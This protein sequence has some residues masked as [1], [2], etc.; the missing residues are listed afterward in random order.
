MFRNIDKVKLELMM[1]RDPEYRRVVKQ[2]LENH[3]LCL[4]SVSHEIRNPL[5]LISS[6]MQLIQAQHPEVIEFS[7]WTQMMEDVEF[8]IDLANEIG[9]FSNSDHMHMTLFSMKHT[10]ECIILSFAM[11]LEGTNIKITGNIEPDITTYLGDRVKIQ[12]VLL[13]LLTNARQAIQ[14]QEPSV[15]KRKPGEIHLHAYRTRGG[16]TIRIRDNGC[17]I[18]PVQMKT[19]FEPFVTHKQDGTGLGLSISRKIAEAHQGTLTCNSVY[20]KGSTFVLAI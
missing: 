4:A 12:E 15:Q 10:L 6:S 20:G 13:N 9:S 16:I 2:L 19:I 7:H 11:S 17:G 1:D 14:C 18:D 8:M 3:R 5:T